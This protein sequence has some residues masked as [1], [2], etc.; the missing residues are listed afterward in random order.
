MPRSIANKKV[1]V[2]ATDGVEESEFTVPIDALKKAEAIVDVISLK[3]GKIKAW[4][5][6]DWGGEYP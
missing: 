3:P 1:A 5:H 4:N 6:T 2:V